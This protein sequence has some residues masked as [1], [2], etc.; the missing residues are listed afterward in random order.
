MPSKSRQLLG[1]V[2]SQHKG[3]IIANFRGLGKLLYFF[4]GPSGHWKFTAEC[5]NIFAYATN[6]IGAL[7]TCSLTEA[8]RSWVWGQ[9]RGHREMCSSSIPLRRIR[10][11]GNSHVKKKGNQSFYANIWLSSFW[12]LLFQLKIIHVNYKILM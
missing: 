5:H 1:G 3:H 7:H 11:R 8:G 6:T 10:N 4:L 9:S 2:R 12:N